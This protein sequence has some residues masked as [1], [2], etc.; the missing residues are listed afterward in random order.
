MENRLGKYCFEKGRPQGSAA[1]CLP[2]PW[3]HGQQG[4][5]LKFKN[6]T[7]TDITV[8]VLFL[9]TSCARPEMTKQ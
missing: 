3:L 2:V 1:G 8:G 9:L 4:Q 5:Q 7:F 6:T